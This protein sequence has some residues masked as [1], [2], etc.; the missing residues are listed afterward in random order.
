MSEGGEVVPGAGGR[1]SPLL[2]S[3]YIKA[4]GGIA[5][6]HTGRYDAPIRQ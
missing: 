6:W 4:R 5:S 1:G 3:S 2:I